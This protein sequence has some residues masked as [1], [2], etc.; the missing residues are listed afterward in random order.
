MIA[1]HAVTSGGT[2]T[3]MLGAASF[4]ARSTAFPGFAAA[5]AP[6]TAITTPTTACAPVDRP[7]ATSVGGALPC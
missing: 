3:A 2:D 4:S 6:T 7:G 1:P 5:N